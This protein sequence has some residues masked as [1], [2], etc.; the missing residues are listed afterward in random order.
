M[1]SGNKVHEV[2]QWGLSAKV[3]HTKLLWNYFEFELV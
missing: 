1:K 3:I 2:L